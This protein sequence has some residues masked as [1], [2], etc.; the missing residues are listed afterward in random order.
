M[1]ITKKR[2]AIATA[3]AALATVGIFGGTY[4]KYRIETLPTTDNARLAKFYLNSDNT[5]DLFKAE[6]DNENGSTGA[7]VKNDGSD[8]ENLIAPNITTV[9]D[10]EFT[11]GTEVKS[12]FRFNGFTVET[13]L[14]EEL[15]RHIIITFTLDGDTTT[16]TLYE[17]L[18]QQVS[19]PSYAPLGDEI[20]IPAGIASEKVEVPVT[21]AWDLESVRATGSLVDD[22]ETAAAIQQAL[23]TAPD[24]GYKL[25]L[26]GNATLTQID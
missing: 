19:A 23:G 16:Q 3:A 22:V 14:P 20:V 18:T 24:G 17:M 26:T 6:Y 1:K 25:N 10:L 4:A 12:A 8:T 5:L 7:D 13:N 11:V 9:G 15:Q 21:L 2:V